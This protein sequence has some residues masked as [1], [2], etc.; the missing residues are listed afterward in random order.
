M[1]NPFDYLIKSEVIPGG[2]GRD[3]PDSDFDP[4][5]LKAGMK[6]E[7]EH[8]EGSNLS[9]EEI[10]NATKEITK[11]HLTES[12]DYYVELKK[13][14]AK[15]EKAEGAFRG[16]DPEYMQMKREAKL[17]Q[18]RDADTAAESEGDVEEEEPSEEEIQADQEKKDKQSEKLA[19]L[20]VDKAIP[21]TPFGGVEVTPPSTDYKVVDERRDSK[22]SDE[23]KGKRPKFK[24]TGKLDRREHRNEVWSE[25]LGFKIPPNGNPL[26]YLRQFVMVGDK[27]GYD[28][29]RKLMFKAVNEEESTEE[30]GPKWLL[31]YVDS[32]PREQLVTVAQKLWGNDFSYDDSMDEEFIRLD[33]K[34]TLLD[35][36]ESKNA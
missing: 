36:L 2:R 17:D 25:A 23:F 34:G 12:K 24:P 32:F 3:K 1:E 27:E 11:D 30:L 6:V 7:R 4:E 9:E 26:S 22:Y 19:S 15:M 21:F 33:I 10:N 18:M 20:N 16:G 5:Q 31:K 29:A 13:M 35:R 28:K 8:I 14:E